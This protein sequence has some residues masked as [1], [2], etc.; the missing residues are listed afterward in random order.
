MARSAIIQTNPS[1]I[2][3]GQ[4]FLYLF[5]LFLEFDG[6]LFCA[7]ELVGDVDLGEVLQLALDLLELHVLLPLLVQ[8]REDVKNG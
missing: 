7:D 2:L 3:S 6:R 5:K 1:V 8:L 4:I